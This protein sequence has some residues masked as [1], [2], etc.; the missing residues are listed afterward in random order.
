MCLG[1]VLRI[2]S[3]LNGKATWPIRA[4]Q[5]LEAADGDLGRAR[6]ELEQ[7]GLLLGRPGADGLPE[8]DDDLV[9]LGVGAV[10][11]VAGPIVDVDLADAA[12][13]ELELA[14][15]KDVDELL[16][17]ELVEARHERLELVLDP[18]LDAPLRDEPAPVLDP[19]IERPASDALD[20][21][22]LVV[23][24]D[25]ALLAARPE[26]GR[27]NLA[28]LVVL[29]AERVL[30]DVR[31]V[32]LPVQRIRAIARE[33][34]EE[35]TA[36]KSSSGRSRRRPTPC[37]TAQSSSLVCG[38]ATVSIEPSQAVS[39]LHHLVKGRDKVS[40][41]EAAVEDGKADDAADEAEVLD[42]LGVDAG[43]CVGHWMLARCGL[44]PPARTFGLICKV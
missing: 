23:F 38:H 13:E 26:V 35:L 37:P 12:D 42:V 32:V 4:L 20:I 8:P 25:R 36:S 41:E 28:K 27:D 2:T 11:G 9:R 21:F 5:V 34:P 29:H 44:T 43:L 10:V 15:V 40:V 30:D 3:L 24:R 33:R 6:R 22:L 31:D 7:A 1:Q 18:L 39:S 14:L 19:T 17:D 16:R